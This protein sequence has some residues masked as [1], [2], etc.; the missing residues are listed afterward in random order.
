MD[1]ASGPPLQVICLAELANNAGSVGIII[2]IQTLTR[3]LGV[4]K[5]TATFL[6]RTE[7]WATAGLK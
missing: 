4:R 5:K 3:K 2:S 6:V 7:P 1:L